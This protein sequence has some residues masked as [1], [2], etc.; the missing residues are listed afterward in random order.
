[1]YYHAEYDSCAGEFRRTGFDP[2]LEYMLKL[3]QQQS[4]EDEDKVQQERN[5]TE[6]E[7]RN[8]SDAASNA[9]PTNHTS[10]EFGA[11]LAAWNE[12]MNTTEAYVHLGAAGVV[13]GEVPVIK[14]GG[15]GDG[16]KQEF[17]G[18][19]YIL[20]EKTRPNV[21]PLLITNLTISEISGVSLRGNTSDFLR[22]GSAEL[23]GNTTDIT[24][25][26]EAEAKHNGVG[27][28]MGG[29]DD[30]AADAAPERSSDMRYIHAC[31]SVILG[32]STHVLLSFCFYAQT[33]SRMHVTYAHSTRKAHTSVIS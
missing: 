12:P 33:H 31:T 22:T 7:P 2:E 28:Q 14:P 6:A 32:S 19:A 16:Q 11:P 18:F 29:K 24:N 15:G 26:T 10:A 9:E 21:P 8:T 17:S 25:V 5:T 20:D 30:L 23:L 27:G 3:A 4:Q 1:M 13:K